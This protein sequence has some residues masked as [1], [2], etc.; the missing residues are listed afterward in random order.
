[1][2]T[3]SEHGTPD[4]N[5]NALPCRPSG[6]S[7]WRGAARRQ[8]PGR[9]SGRGGQRDD[10]VGA[11]VV[12]G[13]DA[14]AYGAAE[15]IGVA[16]HLRGGDGGDVD[17]DAA[18][19]AEAAGIGQDDV[20]EVDG[21]TADGRGTGVTAGEL[22]EVLDDTLEGG[23]L[24]EDAAMRGG[25]VGGAGVG[26]V[27]F[28][29]GADAGERAAQVVGGVG[30]EAPLA[31][32]GVLEAVQH[33]VHR[34]AEAGDLVVATGV[35]DSRAKVGAADA[36]DLRSDGFD[37]AQGASDEG[38]DERRQQGGDGWDDEAEA[39]GQDSSAV[40]DVV[41]RA[42]DLEHD[43]PVAAPDAPGQE[44]EGVR[45]ETRALD[46]P[47]GLGVPGWWRFAD[48]CRAGDVG[49]GGQHMAVGGHDLDDHVL[50]AG[51][52][53]GHPAAGDEGAEVVGL[54][55][56]G[57]VEV[58][59]EQPPLGDDEADAGGDQHGDHGQGGERGDAE[60]KGAD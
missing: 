26:E 48:R 32:G 33:G 60:P 36:G 3:G 25:E 19:G 52:G 50:G 55:P 53:A 1:M 22:E 11:G 13:V 7:E 14:D 16:V 21:L 5:L 27:D 49:A 20:V 30:D 35:G 9:P 45:A 15:L 43:G 23:D 51:E 44:P 40:V 39:G 17:V 58:F 54:L 8:T 24:F 31:P 29:L 47:Q 12:V 2:S 18:A 10:E 56:D 34:A 6:R 4:A 38:P 28:E 59:G 46:G 42:G 41:E 57:V 37:R